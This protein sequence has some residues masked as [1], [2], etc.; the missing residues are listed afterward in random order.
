MAAFREDFFRADDFEAL[1][2]IFC[3]YDYGAN[4]SDASQK[5]S[6]DEKDYQKCALQFTAQPQQIIIAMTVK[7][8]DYFRVL[9]S[10]TNYILSY[11]IGATLQ[12]D[13][14]F[15]FKGK[16]LNEKQ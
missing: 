6:T 8:E 3:S 13:V 5:I 2:P 14:T 11:L 15:N 12:D 9:E 4:T 16:D 1:L 10:Q 7:I